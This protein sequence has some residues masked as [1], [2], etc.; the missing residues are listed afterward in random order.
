MM[1]QSFIAIGSTGHVEVIQH[2]LHAFTQENIHNTQIGSEKHNSDDHNE[3]RRYH[4]LAAR[5]GDFF[6]FTAHGEIEFPRALSPLLYLFTRIHVITVA[7]QEGLEPPTCGFGDRRS[8]N[9]SYWPAILSQRW[10]HPRVR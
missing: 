9:W 10:G 8:T 6:H 7:G 4:L 3:R 2:R 1:Y 5:P